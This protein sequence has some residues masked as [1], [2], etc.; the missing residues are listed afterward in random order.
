MWTYTARILG[1]PA[2][3]W[4][5]TYGLTTPTF[6][7]LLDQDEIPLFRAL[8]GERIRSALFGVQRDGRRRLMT[9]N[10][11]PIHSPDGTLRGAVVAMNDV[12]D[13][14][15]HRMEMLRVAE[16][17]SAVLHAMDA[18]MIL[19]SPDG[20]VLTLNRR[21]RTAGHHRPL[22]RDLRPAD[23]PPG[24]PHVTG[25]TREPRRS[26]VPPHP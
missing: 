10:A 5:S 19:L 6:D 11:S 3:A 12:T 22:G 21:A 20:T 14:E 7:R 17:H 26:V 9:A 25:R 18:G 15:Q 16:H 8:Q 1:T 24:G 2:E 4:A 13:F 23:A